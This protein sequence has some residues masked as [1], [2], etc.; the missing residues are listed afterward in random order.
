[1]YAQLEH[2][3]D[4]EK[5]YYR[6]GD[7]Q[8]FVDQYGVYMTRREA[9]IVAFTAGQVYSNDTRELYSEDLY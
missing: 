1:M 8:G 5:F 6:S 7:D 4:R 2:R 3:D 9:Y